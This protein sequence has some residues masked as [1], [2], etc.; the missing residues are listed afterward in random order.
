MPYCKKCGKELSNSE[1][2]CSSCGT[3]VDSI[4]FSDVV[5]S[6][7]R[8]TVQLSEKVINNVKSND[9]SGRVKTTLQLLGTA[10]PMF[11]VTLVMLVL[12]FFLSFADMVDI[13]IIFSSRSASFLGIFKLFKEYSGS[14]TDAD[15]MIPI[16]T[17]CNV[18]IAASAILTALPLL[19]G[20]KYNNKFLFLNYFS[21]IIVSVIYIFLCIIYTSSD[22]PGEIKLKIT[23]YVYIIQTLAC[24]AVTFVF[25]KKLK[26][27]N[28]NVPVQEKETPAP[29]E[30]QQKET[31]G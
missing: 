27:N 5:T 30:V 15:Y 18:L 31:E 12:N 25:S 4:S 16:L 28:L 8:G 24:F 9:Y 22:S 29:E 23:A 19:F 1:S 20:K 2:F 10:K 21:S 11:F 13:S 7:K 14:G 26:E 6:V 3:K 17:V